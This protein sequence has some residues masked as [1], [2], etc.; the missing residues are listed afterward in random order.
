MKYCTQ[1]AHTQHTYTHTH[2]TCALLGVPGGYREEAADL[3]P[4]VISAIWLPKSGWEQYC[5]GW[6]IHW[7]CIV[8]SGDLQRL[9]KFM[10]TDI[11]PHLHKQGAMF[12]N[13][14]FM[15]R[16]HTVMDCVEEQL[17]NRNKQEYVRHC[18]DMSQLLG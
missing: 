11:D 1:H 16:D 9:A 5:S 14:Y 18:S 15:E 8:S 17:V 6:I 13:K 7:I 3:I 4:H 2:G 12:H 10:R